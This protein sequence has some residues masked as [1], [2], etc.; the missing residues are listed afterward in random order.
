MS[1]NMPFEIQVEII[2]R[3]PLK[4]LVQFQTVSKTWKSM[5]DDVDY[6]ARRGRAIIWNPSIRKAFAL[7][8]PNVAYVKTYGTVLG[9]GVCHETTNP[10]IVKITYIENWSNME[11][12]SCIPYQ[13]EVFTLS[14]GVWRL[15]YGNLPRK[16][17]QF[18]E[19]HEGV[20]VAI[21]AINH[22]ITTTVHGHLLIGLK[23]KS[24]IVSF[25]MTSEKF[26]EIYLPDILECVSVGDLELYK[27]NEYLVVLERMTIV[28]IMEDG[29]SKSFTKLYF[30]DPI[31][32]FVRKFRKTGE[33]VIS[34]NN[35]DGRSTL[36]VYEHD[37]KHV[38]NLGI[39]EVSCV[40][41]VCTYIES[42]LLFDQISSMLYL[43][44]GFKK[45]GIYKGG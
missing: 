33:P 31:S 15:P 40:L 3:L 22:R 19:L 5:I 32:Y 38:S 6:I 16:T 28:W 11:S 24:M 9:F 13:V 37:T 17:I 14:V 43:T 27:L 35:V 34:E 12:I 26:R 39:N 10:K 23:H 4:S 8:V 29:V 21:D 18:N 44:L 41:F 7:D 36:A 30:V 25:D 20:G 2:K 45:C 42:L 1:D